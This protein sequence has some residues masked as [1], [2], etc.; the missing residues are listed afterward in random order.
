M[1]TII[2]RTEKTDTRGIEESLRV[3]H[4]KKRVH[5]SD[6]A[7]EIRTFF[8]ARPT[9]LEGKAHAITNIEGYLKV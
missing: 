1:A 6:E 9:A 7:Y 2:N 3:G 8:H 5:R 4:Y